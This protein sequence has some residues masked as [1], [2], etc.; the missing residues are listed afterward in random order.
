MEIVIIR[1]AIFA[2]KENQEAE[3]IK[4]Q[5]ARLIEKQI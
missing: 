5:Y 4:N 1:L 3:L 2:Y